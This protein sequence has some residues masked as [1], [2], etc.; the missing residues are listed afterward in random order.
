ME[1]IIRGFNHYNRKLYKNY[2]ISKQ[3]IIFKNLNSINKS[4]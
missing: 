2:F 1:H 3:F 4:R